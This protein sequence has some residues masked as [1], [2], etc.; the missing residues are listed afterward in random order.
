MSNDEWIYFSPE[1]K[2]LKD[3]K[4]ANIKFN[5]FEEFWYNFNK[6]SYL[7]V[8]EKDSP[9]KMEHFKQMLK[10]NGKIIYETFNKGLD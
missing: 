9:E 4:N 5:T 3:H 8:G 2:Y 6:N 1:Y 10:D 7:V